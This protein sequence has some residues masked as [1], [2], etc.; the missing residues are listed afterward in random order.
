MYVIHPFTA[1]HDIDTKVITIYGTAR[2]SFP[3]CPAQKQYKYVLGTLHSLNKDFISLRAYKWLSSFSAVLHGVRGGR[4]QN[5]TLLY[6]CIHCIA[7]KTASFSFSSSDWQEQLKAFCAL[8]LLGKCGCEHISA[9]KNLNGFF[10]LCD[11][12][13]Q[14]TFNRRPMQYKHWGQH[15]KFFLNDTTTTP[16]VLSLFICVVTAF[17]VAYGQINVFLTFF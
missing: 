14:V 8:L 5:M 11:L 9:L 17:S 1:L 3:Q 10:F 2:P 13:R 15:S 7:L 16:E 4:I 12:Y 6:T